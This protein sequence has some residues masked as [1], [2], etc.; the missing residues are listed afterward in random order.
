MTR[1]RFALARRRAVEALAKASITAPP[2]AVEDVARTVG[3][4]IRYEPFAGML[5]G[6]AH[7]DA[8]GQAVIGVNSL[9]KT[10][11]QRFTIAHEIGHLVLHLDDDFHIDERFPIGFRDEVSGLAVEPKEIEANQFAAE[12]LM[13]LEWLAKDIQQLRLDFESE[14]ALEELAE[15]YGVSIQAM[16]IRLSSLGV[17]PR[18]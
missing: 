7:R 11:R 6:M 3:A 9:H 14:E 13:P 15:R 1:P 17:L 10:K 16:T 2:V 12:L 8:D 4:A 5:S 18:T